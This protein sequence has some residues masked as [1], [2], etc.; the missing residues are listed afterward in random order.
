MVTTKY[1]NIENV[2][3]LS[4]GFFLLFGAFCVAQSLAVTVLQNDGLN[5]LGFYS[6]SFLYLSFA[7]FSFGSSVIVKKLGN[8]YSLV[9]GA[10]F[11]AIYIASFIIA[12]QNSISKSVIRGTILTTAILCGFGGSI[13]W[14][15]QGNYLSICATDQ[16]KGLF[17]AIFWAV[18]MGSGLIG[19]L[20]AA[21]VVAA[22]NESVFYTIMTALCILAS[23][24]FLLLRVPKRSDS[25]KDEEYEE[26]AQVT[27]R[28]VVDMIMT[29]KMMKA[30]PLI[31]L[32]GVAIA[33]NV[34]FTPLLE[35]TMEATDKSKDWDPDIRSSKIL[36]SLSMLG[37]G[38]IIGSFGTGKLLDWAGPTVT[39]WACLATW[40]A[41][42]GFMLWYEFVYKY[43]LWAGT[44]ICFL[45]GLHE[46]DLGV[47]T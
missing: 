33:G 42:V 6:L 5:N 21:Y 22:F 1:L 11:Y 23:L 20:F 18:Y 13:L 34:L 47:F 10:M 39:M 36:Q 27:F 44:W 46:A 40:V 14:V 15:A 8:K 17:S 29:R 4:L 7:I 26:P 3:I 31:C 32:S 24:S 45:W 41:T 25:D 28:S 19:D 12:S 35:Y 9:V 37:L 2:F 30:V 43:N 38:E 16:N